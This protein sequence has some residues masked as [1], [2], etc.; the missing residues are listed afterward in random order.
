MRLRT[1]VL[2]LLIG[3]PLSGCLWLAGPIG[4]GVTSGWSSPEEEIG[5]EGPEEEAKEEAERAA[6]L[7]DLAS[8]GDSDAQYKL[9]RYH[10]MRSNRKE[11]WRFYCLAANQGHGDAQG[12]LAHY[13][14]Y[15]MEP[16]L[17]N[18]VQAYKWATFAVSNGDESVKTL[19]DELPNKMTPEQAAEAKRMVKNWKP[20]PASCEPKN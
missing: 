13:Y 11:A 20:D 3:P 2:L 19:M 10:R 1:W 7:L 9:G 8:K 16:V 18:N 4:F 15:G 14:A 17:Q 6:F 12:L 5:E